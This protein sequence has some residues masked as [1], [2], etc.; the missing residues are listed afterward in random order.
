MGISEEEFER[1]MPD[2]A[3]IAFDDPSWRSNPRM[4]LVNELVE[5]FWKRLPGTQRRRGRRLFRAGPCKGMVVRMTTNTVWI[6]VDPGNMQGFRD[7]AAER[8]TREN[9]EVVLDFSAVKRI[10][11]NGV[12]ALEDLAGLADEQSVRLVL[13]AVN[14]DIYRVLKLLKLAQRFTIRT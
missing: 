11:T 10:D 7:A 3:K 9:G 1:A 4:P 6:Q 8:L 14:M 5:L 13:C 12:R 2:L